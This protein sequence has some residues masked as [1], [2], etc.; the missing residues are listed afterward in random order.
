MFPV[1]S[2][3][4]MRASSFMA[5]LKSTVLVR[6]SRRTASLWRLKGP[7][8]TWRFF[9]SGLVSLIQRVSLREGLYPVVQAGGL[10]LCGCEDDLCDLVHLILT[11][12]SGRHR[13]CA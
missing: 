9:T 7:S 6:S 8:T 11:H 10:A 3:T 2:A 12:S 5:C 1:A 4:I 13:R